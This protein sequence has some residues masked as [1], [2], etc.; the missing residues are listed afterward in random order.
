[1]FR[2]TSVVALLALT[3]LSGTQAAPLEI[4]DLAEKLQ[5]VFANEAE[6]VSIVDVIDHTLLTTTGSSV[7][8][9]W[10]LQSLH[11]GTTKHIICYVVSKV[12][13]SLLYT[14]VDCYHHGTILQD[15]S[16]E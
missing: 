16:S 5:H 12:L 11:S 7:Q 4:S 1:M 14:R 13:S 3:F 10:I 8:L 9:W 6:V 15:F 2:I